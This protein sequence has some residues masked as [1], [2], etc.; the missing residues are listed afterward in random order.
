MSMQNA[1]REEIAAGVAAG[2]TRV[3]LS[4]LY[5]LFAYC[6]LQSWGVSM[7]LVAA[8]LATPLVLWALA[9]WAWSSARD[10]DRRAAARA[11]V[12]RRDPAYNTRFPKGELFTLG[13]ITV[14]VLTLC[15]IGLV[16]AHNTGADAHPTPIT[17]KAQRA[18]H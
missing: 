18:Q 2:I 12:A 6:L 13:T 1:N 8:V 14:A 17:A 16:N 4:V 3:A 15:G 11:A 5:P 10:W 7:L 9:A